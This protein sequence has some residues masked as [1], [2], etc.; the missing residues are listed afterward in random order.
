MNL[1]STTI[2]PDDP[3][4]ASAGNTFKVL[5]NLGPSI[6]IRDTVLLR[7]VDKYKA[8]NHLTHHNE[9]DGTND[10]TDDNDATM[11]VGEVL[12]L[13][14]SGEAAFAVV[15]VLEEDSPNSHY[16][17]PTDTNTKEAAVEVV[18]SKAA[19][20]GVGATTSKEGEKSVE[21]ASTTG[22]SHA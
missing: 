16:A 9:N 12:T 20:M 21:L 3:D 2:T 6:S 11:T 10:T 15:Q 4:K 22:L 5:S 7:K 1:S 13:L 14:P 8:K 18:A 17:T 19:S